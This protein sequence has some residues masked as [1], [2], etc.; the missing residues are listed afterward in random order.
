MKGRR[1]FI[2]TAPFLFLS[3][4]RRFVRL[5]L[6][7][8][9]LSLRDALP[10]FDSHQLIAFNAQKALNETVR[11]VDLKISMRAVPKAEMKSA[12]IYRVKAGLPHDRLSLYLATIFRYGPRADRATVRLRPDKEDLKPVQIALEI[13]SKQRGRLVQIDDYHVNIAIVV[14]IAEGTASA[15]VDRCDS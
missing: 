4:L 14:K 3:T 1:G 12:I 2:A 13:V 6:N 11:P 8:L 7:T 10:F 15:A 9:Q 5:P